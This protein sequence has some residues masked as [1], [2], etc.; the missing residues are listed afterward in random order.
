MPDKLGFIDLR[1]GH[2]ADG[3]GDESV[4]PSFTDIMTV[5]VMIF[6]MALVVLMVRNLE[7][8]RKLV[9]TMNAQEASMLEN[10]GLVSELDTLEEKV[11]GLQQD[12]Q[13]TEGEREN[14]RLQ[15]L[16]ELQRIELLASDNVGLE[17]QLAEIIEQRQKLAD[18]K[19]QLLEQQAVLSGDLQSQK[20]TSR[21]LT[22]QVMDLAEQGRISGENLEAAAEEKKS[23]LARIGD[24]LASNMDLDRQRGEAESR[25]TDLTETEARLKDKLSEISSQF[26]T[27]KIESASKIDALSDSN[28]SLTGQLER[29]SGQLE[30]VKQLLIEEQQQ[31]AAL[32]LQVESQQQELLQ[33]QALLQQL[34]QIQ[35]QSEQQIADADAEIEELTAL[36]DQRQLENRALQQQAEASGTRFRSLQQEYD[37]L[38]A[39]YRKLIRPAR[40]PAGKHVVEVRVTKDGGEFTYSLKEPGQPEPVSYSR[41]ELEDRLE[42]LKQDHGRNLYTRIVIPENS[43]LSHN[44]A[45]RFTQ[46]ILDRYDYYHQ[47]GAGFQFEGSTS[48]IQ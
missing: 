44:E 41:F 7:L 31:R 8:D 16:R 15:L 6:L 37:S 12:L 22:R 20:E 21:V 28:L 27:L 47:G 11:F 33:R 17:Q 1:I 26:D 24:L 48:V 3:I 29:V 14:L 25:V 5:I 13:A 46:E 10:Q 23:L 42:Q 35:L 4:W 39:R 36:I 32:G 45:W 40:N 43:R 2:G 34:Q 19:M 38:E 30:Q 18:E 9:S